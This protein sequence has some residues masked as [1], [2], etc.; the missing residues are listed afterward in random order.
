MTYPLYTT[1][2]DATT[3]HVVISR[4]AMEL[5]LVLWMGCSCLKKT[6]KWFVKQYM[7]GVN[8]CVVII[9]SCPLPTVVLSHSQL[10]F[11][12]IY[13]CVKLCLIKQLSLL[14]ILYRAFP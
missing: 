10:M 5:D 8:F 4:M 7:L 9:T 12:S 2:C 14:H 1:V 13:N 11:W 3:I 6:E